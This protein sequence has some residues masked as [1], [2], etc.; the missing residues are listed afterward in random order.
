MNIHII[1]LGCRVNQLESQAMADLLEKHGHNIVLD[2]N[3]DA[4]IINTCSVTSEADKKDRMVLR[5]IRKSHPNAKIIFCGCYPQASPKE[6]AKLTEA[7]VII[8]NGNKEKIVE[9]L[10]GKPFEILPYTKL[11]H[12]ENLIANKFD[13][14]YQK[15]FLKIEDGCE[16]FCSYCIIPFAR[17][18]IRSLA[19]SEVKRQAEQLVNFGYKEIVLTGINL[20][21][22]GV[23]IGCDL[24]DAL[25]AIN[26]IPGEFRIRFGSLEPDLL[27]VDIINKFTKCNKLCMHFHLALQSGSNSVLKRMNR[28]YT[29]EEYLQV[30]KNLR[31]VFPSCSFT[32]DVMVGFPGETDEEFNETVSLIKKVGFLRLHIFIYSPRHNTKA[33]S[34]ANQ[35]NPFISKTRA[36][37]LKELGTKL[38]KDAIEF[39]K[40]KPQRILAEEN[41]YGYTD[42]FLHVK[43]P[44]DSCVGDFILR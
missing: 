8:G 20:S 4:F 21:A 26:D 32:T 19:L 34:L 39:Y 30:T 17:G 27:N 36:N 6:M 33:I 24:G 42:E 25:L 10:N 13:R 41:G 16:R 40:D 7:D 23:D 35:V 15:A 5:K 3:A 38:E 12:F 28:K 11:D 22:Y 14:R 18:K 43:L 37:I 9:F 2:E 31:R 44:K 1:T 29:A